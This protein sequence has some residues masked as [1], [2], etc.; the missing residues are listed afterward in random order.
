MNKYVR[1]THERW[2]RVMLHAQKAAINRGVCRC[3]EG[4]VR[5]FLLLLYKEELGD[6]CAW[7]A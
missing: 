5:C 3:P 6:E 2:K 4:S 7:D 1:E